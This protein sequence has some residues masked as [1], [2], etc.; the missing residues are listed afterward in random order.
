MT[1]ND[2]DTYMSAVR[3]KLE[4]DGKWEDVD[5][6]AMEMLRLNLDLMQQAKDTI[7]KEGLFVSSDRGNLAAHPAVRMFKEFQSKAVEIMKDYGLTALS[8]KKLDRGDPPKEDDSPLA[9]FLKRERD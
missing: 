7:D 3:C 6:A 1:Q 5:I 4:G 2:L 8:R 9:E